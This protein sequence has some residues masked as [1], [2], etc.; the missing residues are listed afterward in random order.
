IGSPYVLEKR[1]Q[2]QLTV[3]ENILVNYVLRE[4]DKVGELICIFPE[5]GNSLVR[6]QASTLAYNEWFCSSVVN[7]IA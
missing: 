2:K 3:D 4:D 1:L 5:K 7:A 6:M